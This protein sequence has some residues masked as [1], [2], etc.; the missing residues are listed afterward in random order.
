[1]TSPMRRSA[2]LVL[3][4]TPALSTLTA[5]GNAAS[6]DI[7]GTAAVTVDDAGRPVAL[8]QVCHGWIDTVQVLGDREGL[9]DDE[10]NPTLGTWRTES[11][12]DG[13]VELVLGVVNDGWSG[14]EELALAD[15]RTYV[16]TALDSDEDAEATQVSF[17]TAQLATLAPDHVLVGDGTTRPR[18]ELDCDE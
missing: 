13:T 17:T 18:T 8:V 14:P 11:G 4:L 9:A 7:V 5:C 16:L 15:G 3:L 12:R 10:P 2:H 1:M 6:A